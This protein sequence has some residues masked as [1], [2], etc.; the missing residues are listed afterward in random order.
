VL[1]DAG[2]IERL[3]RG[4]RNCYIVQHDRLAALGTAYSSMVTGLNPG[5]QNLE[6]ELV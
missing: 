5:G 1:L 4:T 6:A 3:P 2:L